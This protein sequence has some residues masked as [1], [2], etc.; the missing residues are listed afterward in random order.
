MPVRLYFILSTA[1]PNSRDQVGIPAAV[2]FIDPLTNEASRMPARWEKV[3]ALR[4]SPA[5]SP[6]RQRAWQTCALAALVPAAE[7]EADLAEWDYDE[8]EGKPSVENR[9]A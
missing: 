8:Y 4:P 9:G 7:I 2:T 1:K 3:S 6:P 5:S